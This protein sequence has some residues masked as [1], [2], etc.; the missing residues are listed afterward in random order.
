MFEGWLSFAGVEL[1]NNARTKV[2]AQD[3]GLTA[4]GGYDCCE[5]LAGY[6]GDRP[7]AQVCADPAPW[8]D[9]AVAASGR[10]AG[11]YGLGVTGMGR[12]T[13]T[14]SPVELLADGAA[15]GA[16]RRRGR[17]FTWR[18]LA[19]AADDA[20]L[21][22][23][24]SWLAGMLRG[25]TC[26][27]GCGGEQ[28]C[29][30][31]HCP[32]TDGSPAEPARNMFHVG[33]LEMD[34][35]TSLRQLNS[36][37]LIEERTFTLLAGIPHLYSPP[38]ELHE[39]Q[40]G[41]PAG[42]H[43]FIP[44]PPPRQLPR[45]G[46]RIADGQDVCAPLGDCLD[47]PAC[48]MPDPPPIAPAP[49]DDCDCAALPTV[50]L[51][52]YFNGA[53]LPAPNQAQSQV[54]ASV[55]VSHGPARMVRVQAGG[56]PLGPVDILSGSAAQPVWTGAAAANLTVNVTDLI[57]GVNAVTTVTRTA[58][59]VTPAQQ[60]KQ[61]VVAGEIT[62][63]TYTA[64]V[65]ITVDKRLITTIASADS[66]PG[67][68]IQVTGGA[69]GEQVFPFDTGQGLLSAPLVAGQLPYTLNLAYSDVASGDEVT[70]APT[71]T[72]PGGVWQVAPK[73]V[74]WQAPYWY[75]RTV[76]IPASLIADAAQRV[77]IVEVYTGSRPMRCLQV[78]WFTNPLGAPCEELTA[79]LCAQ[80]ATFQI[81]YLPAGTR[82]SIDGRTR[83][84]VVDCP[85]VAG[86]ADATAFLRTPDGTPYTWP[87]FDCA[88]P[89]CVRLSATDRADD[90]L[91]S[92]WAAALEDAI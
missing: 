26:T 68:L 61:L 71:V 43:G 77:L 50:T 22:Y 91:L 5:S 29:V 88:V 58:G 15:I 78:E 86:A 66:P 76:E 64:T 7:Y 14:R 1:V 87:V 32:C 53:P 31:A 75:A 37:A 28:A 52:I 82:I 44:R 90:A 4:L 33:L 13:A 18:V 12:S 67:R 89:M 34:E 54:T 2:Y 55:V 38:I 73:T 27:A 11:F 10:F 62:P 72:A 24:T 47:D 83:T 6:L 17:E 85:G 63:V 35:P 30:L 69:L 49:A 23:G 3:L 42:P 79:D 59:T 20:A 57:T 46:M 81:G 16:M 51:T 60:T 48:P 36:G 80:C 41:L 25:S 19:V 74:S 9:E 40:Q 21:S 8:W 92:A 84:A 39:P 65:H 45:G 56:S 70:L